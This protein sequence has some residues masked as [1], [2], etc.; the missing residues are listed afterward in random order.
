MTKPI[1]YGASAPFIRGSS[2]M[3]IQ[4]DDRLIKNDLLQL[5]MTTPGERVM[6]PDYGTNLRLFPFEMMDDI[7]L[8]DLRDSIASAVRK[9]ENRI[10]LDR[11]DFQKDE[12]NN[13]V[14][15]KLYGQTILN[16]VSQLIIELNLPLSG[17]NTEAR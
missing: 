4:A 12:V 3:P 2:I 16:A 7:G 13:T 11:I 14:T 17:K 10:F 9:F 5:L 15:I 6:R 1:W 8:N